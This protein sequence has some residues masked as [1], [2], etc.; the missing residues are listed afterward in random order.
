MLFMTLFFVATAAEPLRSETDGFQVTVPDG[1]RSA[2]EGGG[3]VLG[4]DTEAGLILL[5]YGAGLTA[6]ALKMQASEG[7]RD[8]GL[9]LALSGSPTDATIAKRPAVMAD[10]EG[11]A[12]D[13]TA[14]RAHAVGVVGPSGAVI[15]FGVTTPAQIGALAKRVDGLSA[16]T[17]FFK[18][19]KGT[20][21][22]LSS[23][24][25]SWAGGDS[26]SS[27][28]RMTFDGTGRVAWGSE[29]VGG[30][31][32]KNGLGETNATWSVIN[33][34]QYETSSVGSYSVQ[35]DKVHVK[36]PDGTEQHCGVHVRQS[37]GSV[38]ELKCGD[39]LYATGLCE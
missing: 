19:D 13:G 16:T 15:A 35:G 9:T 23:A 6:D 30:G 10:Y 36:W 17:T 32:L 4:S 18:P 37:N 2:A 14:L 11:M 39:K 3:W 20:V 26:Y 8:E 22:A 1:W 25:C 7:V 12:A 29:F 27:T 28:Q 33:G 31:D 21:A 5:S 24:L 38:T 34:N